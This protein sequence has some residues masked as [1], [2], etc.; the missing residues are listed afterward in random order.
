MPIVAAID[1]RYSRV[2]ASRQTLTFTRSRSHLLL[3][4]NFIYFLIFI[5]TINNITTLDATNKL[6]SAGQHT[7]QNDL[8]SST[9]YPNNDYYQESLFIRPMIDGQ[10]HVEFQ[11]DTFYR[12]DLGHLI[13]G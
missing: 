1:I 6:D 2:D 9:S 13:W 5:I 12:S 4:N 3:Y 10:I 11:F 8:L 7:T